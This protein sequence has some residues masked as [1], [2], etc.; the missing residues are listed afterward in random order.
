MFRRD[1]ILK[2]NIR[3]DET[4]AAN[5]QMF[6]AKATCWANDDA[7]A[8]VP[9]VLYTVTTRSNSLMD[10]WGKD[11]RNYL[12]R[13]GVQIQYNK[14]VKDYPYLRQEPIIILLANSWHFG[15]KTFFKALVLVLRKNALFSGIGLK[16]IVKHL[17]LKFKL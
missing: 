8:I 14:F 15:I 4:M 2:H 11:P 12:C 16:K 3:F 13:L 17:K 9:D 10:N 1:Y 7:V 5:D 6:V